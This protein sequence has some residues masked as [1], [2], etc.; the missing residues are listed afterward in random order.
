MLFE[1]SATRGLRMMSPRR[2]YTATGLG[3]P[4]HSGHTEVAVRT[5]SGCNETSGTSWAILIATNL[6][7]L[8]LNHQQS[9]VVWLTQMPKAAVR[10]IL[11]PTVPAVGLVYNAQTVTP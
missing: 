5:R 10:P 3:G 7:R 6:H 2:G 8:I 1:L 9:R 11:R 4:A